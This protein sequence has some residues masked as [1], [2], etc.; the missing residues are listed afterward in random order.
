[1]PIEFMAVTKSTVHML[2]QEVNSL[3]AQ[4]WQPFGNILVAGPQTIAMT[5]GR[6]DEITSS[7]TEFKCVSGST[8]TQLIERVNAASIEGFKVFGDSAEQTSQYAVAMIIGEAGGGSGEAGPQGP[9][10]PAGPQG[11]AGPVGPQG[12]AG[13]TGPAGAAGVKGDKGDTGAQGPIGPTGPT[14]PAGPKGDTGPAG[15]TGATGPQGIQGDA[16]PVGPAGLEFVGTYDPARS[17]V[18]GDVVTYNNSSWFATADVTGEA[19][20]T[21]DSW[22]LL[23]AQGAVGPQG[24]TGPKGDTGPAGATGPAGPAGPTGATGPSGPQGIQG[25][26]GLT[27]A[28]GPQ[29]PAGP[30]GIQGIAGPQGVRGEKGDKGDPGILKT[31]L[32]TGSLSGIGTNHRVKLPAPL[33]NLYVGIRLDS[34]VRFSIRAW[35]DEGSATRD[36]RGNI[37]GFNNSG[38]Y[39]NTT[40]R[41]SI[42]SSATVGTNLVSEIGEFQSIRPYTFTFC[43]LT[44]QTIWR[45]TINLF[46]SGYVVTGNQ[47]LFMEVVRLDA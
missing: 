44:T 8:R 23:A 3:I 13:A 6:G 34:D 40:L 39:S 26:Q 16:G 27:G 18:A 17:Y 46:P 28:A 38:T 33:D 14:G 5:V 29:G 10:G 11:A 32:K 30:Q 22:E 36:I 43:E 9:T 37:E 15:P 12:P 2:N 19:P 20:D 21:S 42:S 47:W 41:Q 35:I 31:I 1:M 25:P 24:P 4:G 45:V 7:I